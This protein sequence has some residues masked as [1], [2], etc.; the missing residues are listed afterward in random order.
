MNTKK[1]II[2]ILSIH[3]MPIAIK[4]IARIVRQGGKLLISI[5][6]V[7]NDV[8]PE[9]SRDGYGRLYNNYSSKLYVEMFK[10]AGFRLVFQEENKDAM[11]RKFNWITMGF[12]KE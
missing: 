12:I 7:R 1:S 9:T 5:P 8:D 2:C 4:N 3:E 6:S 11:K 10:L